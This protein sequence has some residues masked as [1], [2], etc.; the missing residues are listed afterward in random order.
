LHN[1]KWVSILVKFS[2]EERDTRSKKVRATEKRIKD[3]FI[4][5][6]NT[7]PARG[8]EQTKEML[9]IYWEE[10]GKVGGDFDKFY[11]AMNLPKTIEN[12]GENK[13]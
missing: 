2:D 10:N 9:R 13:S 11:K 8:E 12:K 5:K 4:A 6:Y 1:E 3:R 7:W